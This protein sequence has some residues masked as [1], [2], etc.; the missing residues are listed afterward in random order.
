MKKLNVSFDGITD[1][2]GYLFSLA[3][4]FAAVLNSG[5][6][7][8]YAK[9]I[10]AASG[11]AFRMWADKEQ[12]CPSATSIWE[13]KKQKEWFENSGLLCGYV[14]RLWGEDAVEEERRTA[15]VAL[16]KESIRQGNAAVAWDISGCEWGIITGYDDDEQRFATLKISGEEGEVAYERLGLLELPILSVLTV[17]GT[18]PKETAQMISDTKKLAACHLDGKEWC[19][20]ASG[21]SAYDAILTFIKERLSADTAWNLEYYLGT[22]AALKWHAWKFFEKYNEPALA[23][24]YKTIYEAW[25]GAFDVKRSKDV[26]ESEVKKELA[27]FL[28]VAKDA[29]EKAAGLM[30]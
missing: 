8:E 25:Q 4:C 19:D 5:P 7:K 2:T 29:E 24:L 13:F 11:F 26:T 16:I 23:Q 10:I 27:A 28:S 3:K 14:E 9:D 30:R 18:T 15:A 20:N 6:C 22:Y 17:S 1:T 12:L 21:L